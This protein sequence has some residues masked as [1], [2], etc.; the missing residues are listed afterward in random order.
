MTQYTPVRDSGG[1]VIAVLF[2]GFDYTD[3]QKA[4]FDN[5]KSFRIGSTGS[6]AL[7]DEQNKWLVPPAAS[8]I[9]IRRAK[10]WLTSSRRRERGVSGR[11]QVM[12]LH[13]CRAVRGWP[14]VDSGDHAQG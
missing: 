13:R 10:P 1:K 4:Q 7:L 11:M 3:A 14:V 5:L 12:I 8:K 6:L 2:V 9:W